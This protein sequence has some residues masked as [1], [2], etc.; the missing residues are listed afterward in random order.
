MDLGQSAEIGYGSA[1][2]AFILTSFDP[3]AMAES[4]RALGMDLTDV[5][6]EARAAG[7]SSLMGKGCLD[8]VD[9]QASLSGV[10]EILG[11]T[12]VAATRWTELGFFASREEMLDGA[13]VVSAPEA[14]ILMQPRALGAWMTVLKDPTHSDADAVRSLVEAF[15]GSTPGGIVFLATRAD[16]ESATLFIR[17]LPDGRWEI[18]E[19]E[20]TVEDGEVGTFDQAEAERILE[21]VLS[22]EVL[23]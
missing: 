21:R 22:P 19:G 11:Y 4:A 17:P 13:L 16:G 20:A 6:D 7:A 18:V 1:E 2:L 3:D 12:L 5:S 15:A 10:A 23:R 14:T 9:G 8:I